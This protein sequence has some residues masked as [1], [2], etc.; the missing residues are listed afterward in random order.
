MSAIDE[1]IS[2]ITDENL[3]ANIQREVAKLSARK[4]F[5]LVFEEHLPECTPLYGRPLK[6]G[7]KAALRN[8]KITKIYTVLKISGEKVLCLPRDDDDPVEIPASDLV[9][10]AEF[11]EAIYPYLREI[12]SVCNDPENDLWHVLIEAEN[13]H[14]LQLLEYICAGKVDCIYID[15]PYNTGARDWKYNND[16]VD[17]NDAYRHSK[18]LSFMSKR[19]KLARNL[20]K[21][22][23]VLIVAIDDYECARLTQLLEELFPAYDVNTVVI[24]HHPQGGSSDNISRTHEYA[25]F[26]IPRG[27]QIIKGI[28]TENIN[29]YWSLM[30][31][32]TDIRNLRAGR[33]NSF[34]AI[35]VDKESRTVKGVGPHLD[36]DTPYDKKE[37]PEGCIAFYP[38]GK[39]GKER[40]WRY[41]RESM[42]QHI[43]NGEI[44][45]TEKMT[46]NVVKHRDVKYAPVFS[47]WTDGK[48][49]AGT[50]GTNMLQDILGGQTRFSYPKSLYTIADCIR[51]SIQ[52]KPDALILDFFA[53]SGTTLH[54]VNLLNAEDSGHRRCIMVTNNEVSESESRTLTEK[55]FTPGTPEWDSLGIARY[56]TWPRTVCAITG[57][58]INGQ[59]LKGTYARSNIPMS[60]G[61]KSNAAFFS[62]GFLDKDSVALGRK[63]REILPLLWLKSGAFGKCPAV[64][65]GEIPAMLIL[66]ENKFAVLN[67]EALFM[68]F[69]ES[70]NSRGE[71]QTVFIVTDYDSGF[72]AMAKSINAEKKYQLYRDYLDNFRINHQR[73]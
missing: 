60:D 6:P 73:S 31:G 61:F 13:Y 49:N 66:P 59:P 56:V 26:V 41:E 54:A 24:N 5:G 57:Q 46:L 36:A 68:E 2:R 7:S 32:G 50:F 72:R 29:E 39:D 21:Q 18:W 15:P 43:N 30:R 10:I 12:D 35:Y 11:G 65:D 47:V 45:C 51:F 1:L 71:I 34:Y 20:L 19:L 40:V 28:K 37:A 4:K 69:E 38:V 23:G 67:D 27:Q 52:D 33:P 55:G 22:D 3:R 58:D 42:L 53:G 8:G 14:A 48:Y 44:I 16:Y 25:L 63:F 17:G 64:Y 9:C 62:L 70:V